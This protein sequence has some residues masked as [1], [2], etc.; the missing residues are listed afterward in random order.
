[1]LGDAV[2]RHFVAADGA[3]SCDQRRCSR[4]SGLACLD[5]HPTLLPHDPSPPRSFCPPTTPPDE[6]E[7]FK[8]ALNIDT[9]VAKLGFY[10]QQG[11]RLW[12]RS[13]VESLHLWEWAAA[14][15]DEAAG[16]W[17]G[18][19]LPRAVGAAAAAT[20]AVWNAAGLC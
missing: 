7:G 13:G 4:Q 9:S 3:A 20:A 16:A 17:G 2:L 15:N 6:D 12:A 10:G 1:M 14:C 8:A 5:L 18:G 19:L 11:E